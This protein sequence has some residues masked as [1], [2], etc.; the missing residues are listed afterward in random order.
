[1]DLY[2]EITTL[3]AVLVL[4]YFGHNMTVV[5]ATGIV[6]ALKVISLLGL[7]APLAALGSHGLNWGIILLTA[8]IL[9]PIATGEIT[10]STMID[11]FKS[12]P[13]LI[14]ITAGLL[15]AI[16]GGGGVKLLSEDT[17]LIPALIIGTMVGVIAFKGVAVGPLIAG[18]L[19]YFVMFLLRSF[20]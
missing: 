5:Y 16:A 12:A 13:G 2:T 4:A 17:E 14:A 10:I 20:H 9:V 3:L 15:A 6:L 1:M 19:T 8:A 7:T 11:S 18:G